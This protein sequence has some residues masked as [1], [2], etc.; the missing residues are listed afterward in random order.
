M[1]APRTTLAYQDI[2]N[3]QHW[4]PPWKLWNVGISQLNYQV[5]LKDPLF[6]GAL[7]PS[8]WNIIFLTL[9]SVYICILLLLHLNSKKWTLLYSSPRKWHNVKYCTLKYWNKINSNTCMKTEILA[10]YWNMSK[11]DNEQKRKSFNEQSSGWHSHISSSCTSN[12]QI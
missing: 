2:I 1:T 6:K 7:L 12:K 11:L 9:S 4:V 10:L 5:T 3:I 8:K